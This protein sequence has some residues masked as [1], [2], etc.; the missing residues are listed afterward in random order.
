[1]RVATPRLK[2]GENR[3]AR[4]DGEVVIVAEKEPF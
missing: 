2:Y 1:V 3:D 4:V